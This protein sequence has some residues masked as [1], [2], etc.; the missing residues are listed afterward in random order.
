MKATRLHLLRHGQ[1]EGF[2]NKRYNGQSDIRLTDFGCQQSAAF[3]GRFQY[4]KLSAIYSSDLSRCRFAA[5]QIAIYQDVQPVYLEKLRELH[6]GIGRG[7]P[8]NNC[9]VIILNCGRP[10]LM[11]LSMWL[12][13]PGG[14]YWHWRSGSVR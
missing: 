6:I 2:E 4:Q 3:A 5:D 13:P 11:I 7:K 12:P 8:G 9:S 10:D 14:A 1:V